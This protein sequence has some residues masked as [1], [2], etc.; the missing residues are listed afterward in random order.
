MF[1]SVADLICSY[2]YFTL[3]LVTATLRQTK[4]QGPPSRRAGPWA[5]QEAR[6]VCVN[7]RFVNSSRTLHSVLRQIMLVHTV[8]HSLTLILLM[9]R[10]GWAKSIPIHPTRCIVTQFI[11]TCICLMRGLFRMTL[12]TAPHYV[13]S[14]CGR[15]R[16]TK[17]TKAICC[18]VENK[19]HPLW[20]M[21]L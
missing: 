17:K 18:G 14:R 11:L 8:K 3:R 21:L 12:V 7:F 5:S 20:R 9:W 16:W 4:M 19:S 1:S 2:S 6:V 15:G 10:T 13:T